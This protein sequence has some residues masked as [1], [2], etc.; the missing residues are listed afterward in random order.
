MK[1]SRDQSEP[2]PPPSQPNDGAARCLRRYRNVDPT[3]DP[4]VVIFKDGD[5]VRQDILCLQM[6]TL[7]KNMWAQHGLD[8]PL[9]PY[10]C[11]TLGWEVGMLEVVIECD[12]LS[13]ITKNA[14]GASGVWDKN[15]LDDWLRSH[16]RD[17]KSYEVLAPRPRPLPT[18]VPFW[19]RKGVST[20]VPFQH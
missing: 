3:A 19:C 6:F 18:L 16:N 4:I 7:M 1:Q 17:E 15:I 8:V 2:A 9:T 11:T 5:D 13:N 14:K 10:A 20:L 12:T